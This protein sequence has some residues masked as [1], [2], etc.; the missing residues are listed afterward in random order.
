L[1]PQA[2]TVMST[3][4]RILLV[5]D[6]N[7]LRESLKEQ[8]NLQNEFVVTDAATGASGLEKAKSETP[9]LVILDGPGW[10]R[11]LPPHA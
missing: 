7:A 2:A 9:D 1:I 10:P 5:D 8:L 11:G 6:D 3:P 4:R